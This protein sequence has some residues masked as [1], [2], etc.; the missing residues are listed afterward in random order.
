VRAAGRANRLCEVPGDKASTEEVVNYETKTLWC[1]RAHDCLVCRG[2]DPDCFPRA[3]YGL[4]KP[5]N[6]IVCLFGDCGQRPSK[7]LLRKIA[8]KKGRLLPVLHLS[9]CMAKKRASPDIIAEI[10]WE[11]GT[12]SLSQMLCNGLAKQ[13]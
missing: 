9:D 11:L 10:V 3:H 4:T 2:F 6:E 1:P 7:N 13:I 8:I 5:K 12:D